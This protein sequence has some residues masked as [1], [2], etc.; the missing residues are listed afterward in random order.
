MTIQGTADMVAPAL[1]GQARRAVLALLFGRPDESFYLREI[2]RLTGTGVGVLQRELK[3]LGQAGLIVR[4]VDG[5]QVYFRANRGSPVF[6]ELRGLMLKTAGVGDVLRLALAAFA[7]DGRIR[8]AFVYGSVAAGKAGAES[9]VDLIVIGSVRLADLLPTVRRA[10]E[11][12]GREVNPT[13]FAP[14]DLRDRV[15]RGEPFIRRVLEGDR[16][17]LIG[18]A[19]ELEALAGQRLVD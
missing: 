6:E 9:D 4:T 7:N 18:T 10:Q 1:F 3:R 11:R 8:V 16:L 5:R 13:V 2:A 15:Q 19:D 17:F 14:E 12:I